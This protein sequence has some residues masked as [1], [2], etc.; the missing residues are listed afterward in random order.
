[1]TTMLL[2][3]A[4]SPDCAAPMF[5]LREKSRWREGTASAL[6]YLIQYWNR[7]GNSRRVTIGD[8]NA[9]APEEACWMVRGLLARVDDLRARYDP[10]AEKAKPAKRPHSR[11][12]AESGTACKR[13]R[14]GSILRGVR[15]PSWS[16]PLWKANTHS[17]SGLSPIRRFR[18]L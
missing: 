11:G 13:G 18:H 10:A 2:G 3:R 5:G 12:R 7:K 15:N 1:M 6:S 4:P 8:A 17:T 14:V 9:V 16:Q